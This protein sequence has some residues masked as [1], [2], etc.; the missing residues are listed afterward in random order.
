MRTSEPRPQ[1]AVSADAMAVL[2]K[3]RPSTASFGRGS[4]RGTV[5]AVKVN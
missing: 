5:E 4:G 3:A 1:E 2:D